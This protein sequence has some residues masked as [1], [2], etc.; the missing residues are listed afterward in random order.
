MLNG[1]RLERLNWLADKS[2]AGIRHSSGMMVNYVYRLDEVERSHEAY[3]RNGS[4]VAS[5]S[6]QQ[7]AKQSLLAQ[8]SKLQSARRNAVAAGRPVIAR[9]PPAR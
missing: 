5:R 8:G 9:L 4:I 6:L 7:L 2:A 1:A 3:V